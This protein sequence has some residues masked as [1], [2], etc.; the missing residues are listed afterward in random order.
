MSAAEEKDPRNSP[1]LHQVLADLDRHLE[2]LRGDIGVRD[3]R[4]E[5]RADQG[6]RYLRP[7]DAAKMLGVSQSWL[8]KARMRGDPP[9]FIRLTKRLIAY[10]VRELV[11]YCDERQRRS[12][13]DH[14]K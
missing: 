2:A 9:R 10:D 12:T 14:G 6:P 3:R 13:S 1:P 11:R 8:A 7:P 4:G 5:I